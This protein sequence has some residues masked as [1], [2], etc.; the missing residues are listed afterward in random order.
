[1]AGLH[2]ACIGCRSCEQVCPQEIKISEAMK[3][4]V[5]RLKT[6]KEGAAYG[7]KPI[8]DKRA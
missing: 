7:V 2:T 5:E 6:V 1:M 3:D 4:F 8:E